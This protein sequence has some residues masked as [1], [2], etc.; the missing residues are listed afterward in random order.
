[1]LGLGLRPA[2]RLSKVGVLSRY[3]GSERN[4]SCESLIPKVAR[5]KSP[6]DGGLV[7]ETSASQHVGCFSSVPQ[8][9]KPKAV[10]K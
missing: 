3:F 5:F 8:A 2:H 4:D 6:A 10:V 1:M 7:A 9:P